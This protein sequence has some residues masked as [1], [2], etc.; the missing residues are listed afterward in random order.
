MQ[1][2]NY[3]TLH[4]FVL[5]YIGNHAKALV[6]KVPSVFRD[7]VYQKFLNRQ[8][9]NRQVRKKDNKVFFKKE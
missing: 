6:V 2:C 5:F 4:S 1:H 9:V 3:S 8:V 7:F